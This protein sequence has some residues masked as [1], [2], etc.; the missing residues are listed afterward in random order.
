[1]RPWT[2]ETLGPAG[3]SNQHYTN[4][5]RKPKGRFLNESP[6]QGPFIGVPYYIGDLKGG[7]NLEKYPYDP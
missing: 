3:P 1:M 5:Q 7:P 2:I 4:L 6:F